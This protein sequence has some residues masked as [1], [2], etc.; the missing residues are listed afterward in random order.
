[1]RRLSVLMSAFLLAAGMAVAQD[2]D[3]S[4]MNSAQQPVAESN[5]LRG[6]LTAGGD[7]FKLTTDIGAKVINLQVDK[8]AATPYIA[9]E[10]EVQGTTVSDGTFR[11]DRILD[12][13]DHCGH[14]TPQSNQRQPSA[15]AKPPLT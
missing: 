4:R 15:I 1:M 10:V 3:Q 14:S 9:H 8:N 12:I 13:A 2:S 7:E 5:H 11:V 6:C